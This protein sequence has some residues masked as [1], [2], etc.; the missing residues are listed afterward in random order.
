MVSTACAIGNGAS[1]ASASVHYQT[2]LSLRT[3]SSR[4]A[5]PSQR[6]ESNGKLNQP[7]RITSAFLPFS[8]LTSNSLHANGA[9]PL[10][11]Q[12]QQNQRCRQTFNPVQRDH[13]LH[14]GNALTYGSANGRYK[15][16]RIRVVHRDLHWLWEP[17]TNRGLLKKT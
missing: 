13:A 9:V 4:E 3:S 14:A 2:A 16:L 1:W 11:E 15:Q 12:W 17:D 10:P 5:P 8:K 7:L 6:F